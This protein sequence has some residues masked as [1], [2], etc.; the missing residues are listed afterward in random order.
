MIESIIIIASIGIAVYLL[1]ALLLFLF[2]SNNILLWRSRRYSI[3]YGRDEGYQERKE[4]KNPRIVYWLCHNPRQQNE[5][6]WVVLLHSWGRNSGRMVTRAS[7]YWE[8]GFSLIFLDARSHGESEYSWPSNGFTFGEDAIRVAE[9]EGIRNPIVHGLSAGAI[10]AVVFAKHRQVRALVLEAL[11]SDYETMVY[12]TMR[13]F[14]LPRFLFGWVAR[15]LLNQNLPF[16]FYEPK[17]VL[18]SLDSPIFLIHGENDRWFLPNHHYEINKRAL[19]GK[20]AEFWLV[21]G[22]KHSKMAQHPEYEQKLLSFL[23]RNVLKQKAIKKPMKAIAIDQPI[24][25]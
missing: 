11:V 2:F 10:A 24:K 9:K 23:V 18:P 3:P 12:D 21:P 14:H 17:K 15:L 6:D 8:L 16:D 13:F 22:S 5:D 7:V 1:I 4:L 19:K 20:D 25:N